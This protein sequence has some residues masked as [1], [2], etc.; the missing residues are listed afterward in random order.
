MTN[1]H[2]LIFIFFCCI[3][4]L[5]QF[6]I[7]VLL[8]LPLT[9]LHVVHWVALW[10]TALSL[11]T[12][13]SFL[14]CAHVTWAWKST[15]GNKWRQPRSSVP[16]CLSFPTLIGTIRH[17]GH[18][19]HF[20]VFCAW[21]S[22]LHILESGYPKIWLAILSKPPNIHHTLACLCSEWSLTSLPPSPIE[23]KHNPPL[24]PLLSFFLL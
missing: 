12:V 19:L 8:P 15:L 6:F 5:H 1:L 7:F 18:I 10:A 24:P 3:H 21:F 17:L 22:L 4:Y 9:F 2:I 11:C 14:W 13:S 16:V 20:I 23:T